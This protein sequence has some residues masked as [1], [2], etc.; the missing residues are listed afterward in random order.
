MSTPLT[1]SIN[2][3]TTYANEI[4]GA[5]D[6]TLSDAVHTLASGYGVGTLDVFK[7]GTNFADLFRDSVLPETVEIDFEGNT[8][9]TS[10]ATMFFRTSGIKHLII[11]N[12]I[13]T[14]TN[15]PMNAFLYISP[16]IIDVTFDN[17]SFAPSS[18][19][20]FGRSCPKLINVFGE[21]DC[22]NSTNNRYW[23]SS[24]IENFRI[25]K[26]TINIGDTWSNFGTGNNNITNETLASIGNGLNPN[27]S[28]Q[29]LYVDSKCIPRMNALM[30]D[31]DNGDFVLNENGAMSLADF[32]ITVKGWSLP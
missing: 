17:C 21:I 16:D 24:A 9:V 18:L 8:N 25:K 5:S 15:L 28:G 23:F 22:T 31:N 4:T 10:M 26:N 1:D 20:S 6:T 19:E 30:G 11:K 2:A 7:I 13:S 29:T 3:L 32:I 12:L 27:V 14:K